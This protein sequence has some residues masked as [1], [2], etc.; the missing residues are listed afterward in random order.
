MQIDSD[1]QSSVSDTKCVIVIPVYKP[2]LNEYEKISLARCI[3]IFGKTRPIALATYKKLDLTLYDEA[4]AKQ[5]CAYT[6]QYFKRTYFT[7]VK[8]YSSLLLCKD[9]YEPFKKYGFMLLY[10]LDAYVFHDDLKYWCDRPYDYVGA[11]FLTLFRKNEKE[12][13]SPWGVG[14]GGLSLRRIDAFLGAY[15]GEP[16]FSLAD[17]YHNTVFRKNAFYTFIKQVCFTPRYLFR[18]FFR[19][20]VAAYI[21]RSKVN[22]DIFWCFAFNHADLRA[23]LSETAIEHLF[24]RTSR[25]S[26]GSLLKIATVDEALLFAFDEDPKRCLELTQGKLPMGCHAFNKQPNFWLEH[27]QEL[28]KGK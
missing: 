10:Q 6:T 2:T 27:I 19:N 24:L 21:E 9:F 18:F 23:V 7:S 3:S 4:F 14:N 13:V 12:P 28:Q 22:E 26:S 1:I 20:T 25:Y 15:S 8:G 5:Q 16:V 11:P 17:Y